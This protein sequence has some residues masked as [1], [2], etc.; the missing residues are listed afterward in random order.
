MKLLA[1]ITR[2]IIRLPFLRKHYYGIY[3]KVLRPL[4]LFRSTS[5]IHPYD[6]CLKIKLDIGDWLQQQIYFFDAFD[7]RG[8]LF[9]KKN[10]KE[11]DVFVDVGANIGGYTLVAARL[12]GE[13]GKVI[14]FEPVKEIFDRLCFNIDLNKLGNVSAENFAVYKESGNLTIHV[15]DREN[16][17]MSS[18][19]HHDTESGRTEKAE[20]I[21]L[22]D[23][24]ASAGIQKIKLIK[25]DI[26][27]AELEALKGMQR[28]LRDLRPLLIVE[29]SDEVLISDPARKQETLDW[30]KGL[31]YVRKWLGTNGQVMAEPDQYA[32]HYFNFVFFP[33]ERL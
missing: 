15:S 24:V 12:V 7:E 4:G 11:G 22:D 25:I 10:L 20:A 31:G 14:A 5:L 13:T 8:L 3:I 27:G 9:L 26:E 28:I 16:M 2:R 30:L 32:K 29:I 1:G 6:E 17:G 18:I 21:A 33:G 19:F 23:Y